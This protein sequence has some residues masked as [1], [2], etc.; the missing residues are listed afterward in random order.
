MEARYEYISQSWVAQHPDP[1]GVVMFYGGE[2][3]GVLPTT[4]YDS[5]LQSLFDA[6]YT[7]IAISVDVGFNHYAIAR[8]LL[9]RRDAVYAQLPYLEEKRKGGLPHFWLGHSVGCKMI[10]L[11][12]ALTNPQTGRFEAPEPY[13]YLSYPN[14]IYDEP[15]VLMAPDIADTSAALRVPF[16]PEILDLLGLGIRPTRE[17]TQG[18]VAGRTDLFNLTGLL[19]FEGDTIAG[20]LNQPPDRSDVAWFAQ[21]FQQRACYHAAQIPGDHLEP[22]GVLIARESC[23][24]DF[25]RLVVC[26]A[27]PRLVE[28]QVQTLIGELRTCRDKGLAA[29]QRLL[30]AATPATVTT[31]S[32]ARTTT[33]TT[34][35]GKA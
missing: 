5:L 24:L 10:V 28:Q 29:R 3:F 7:I 11:L 23:R 26:E 35:P 2:F 12:E 31:P 13:S 21:E 32:P 22:V 4:S 33:A 25:P 17:Q 19:A 27:T 34:S 18:F 6:G 9:E 16:L 8:S 15:S 1:I 14:G 20:N 30:G